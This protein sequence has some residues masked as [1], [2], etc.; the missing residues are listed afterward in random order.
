M[1]HADYSTFNS[2]EVAWYWHGGQVLEPNT[3]NMLV[4]QFYAFYMTCSQEVYTVPC[5]KAPT[6]IKAQTNSYAPGPTRSMSVPS[7]TTLIVHKLSLVTLKKNH[8]CLHWTGQVRGNFKSRFGDYIRNTHFS[9]GVMKSAY[10][11]YLELQR[12]CIAAYFLKAFF[13]HVKHC[14]VDVHTRTISLDFADAWLGE[15]T[16]SPSQASGTSKIDA[17]TKAIHAFAHFG[18]SNKGLVIADIQGMNSGISGFG[19]E[20]ATFTRDNKCGT[21]C[22]SPGVDQT[23]VLGNTLETKETFSRSHSPS[24]VPAPPIRERSESPAAPDSEMTA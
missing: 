13:K 17:S 18:H 15:E 7:E 3:A 23:I 19:P 20:I 2:E 9:Q 16:G 14:G 21:I 22:K 8:Q 10:D 24:D 4:G 1:F 11:I 12:L 5:R 6:E